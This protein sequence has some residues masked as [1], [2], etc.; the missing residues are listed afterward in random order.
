[1][2]SHF[3]ALRFIGSAGTWSP[4]GRR[5]AFVSSAEGDNQITIWSAPDEEVKRSFQVEGVTA[6]KNPA[7]SPGGGRLAFVGNDGGVSDLYVLDLKTKDVRQLTDDRYA[8]L[9]PTWSPG[10]E[11]IAFSTDRAE[12]SLDQLDLSK[13]MDL[14]LIDVESGE[15][16]VREPF[17]DALHHNPQFS[18]DGQSLYFISDQGGF[19]D[20]YRMERSSGE[21][22]RVTRLKTGVS[23]ITALSPAMSVASTAGS[24]MFSVYRDGRYTGVRLPASEA[25][26]SPLTDTTTAR[27]LESPPSSSQK[28]GGAAGKPSANAGE[29]PDPGRTVEK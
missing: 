5:L 21:L 1:M 10:G 24:V 8:D 22:F 3:N 13:D 20:I 27:R 9:Q 16:S 15:V 7:W 26:G 2:T 14:G 12:T 19:K 25:Q 28:T 18:P 11:T 29:G 17:G 4:N 6:L 23:G